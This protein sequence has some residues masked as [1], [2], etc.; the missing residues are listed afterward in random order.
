[1]LNGSV[2]LLV[3]GFTA[4]MRATNPKDYMYGFLGVT[5]IL[6]KPDY[7]PTKSITDVYTECIA[8]SLD[9]SRELRRWDVTPALYFLVTA[10]I[11]IH[12]D[13]SD[14]PSWAPNFAASSKLIIKSISG[15]IRNTIETAHQHSQGE[16]D[17]IPRLV[18]PTRSLFVHGV[19][20]DEAIEVAEVSLIYM[21]FGGNMLP[22]IR[23][24]M[25]KHPTYISG[26]AP[27]PAF[28]RLFDQV[29]KFAHDKAESFVH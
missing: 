15:D 13:E 26:I 16:E 4:Q 8:C 27:L 24:F 7:S 2:A 17:T 25:T 22:L 12:G 20:V 29:K 11:G 9:T 5:R 18:L 23:N 6:L 3:S 1:M 28:L 21:W 14:F 10:G 19:K